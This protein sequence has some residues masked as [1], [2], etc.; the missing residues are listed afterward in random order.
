MELGL[1]TYAPITS[2]L[3]TPGSSPVSNESK[4]EL[5]QAIYQYR[6]EIDGLR[7]LA[8]LA[9]LINHINGEWLKGGY[10][11]VDSFFCDFRLCG[12][13]ITYGRR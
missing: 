10:I 13:R 9:I 1:K 4:A 6:P 5:P 11:G 2:D 7:A 12:D 8:F 3:M